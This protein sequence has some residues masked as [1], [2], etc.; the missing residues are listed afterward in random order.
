M[1]A[2]RVG[3]GGYG[4]VTARRRIAGL[5]A[6]LAALS[7]CWPGAHGPARDPVPTADGSSLRASSDVLEG[8]GL[9]GGEAARA[10]AAGG[11]ALIVLGA[12]IASESDRVG[13]FVEIPAD[14]CVLLF[15]RATPAV[16]DL[17]LLAYDDEGNL[18]ASDESPDPQPTALLCPPHPRRV[19]AAARVV[20]G[21]GVVALGAV[22]VKRSVAAAVAAACQARGRGDDTGRLAAWPGL[23]G[24]V[25]AHRASLG[26]R[27]EDAKR[28][29][30]PVDSRV[31]TRVSLAVGA[32]RCLDVLVTPSDEIGSLEVLAEDASARV[33]ARGRERGR[34]RTLLLCSQSAAE[35]SLSLRARASQ[36]LAAVVVARSRVGGEAE[37]SA[38]V[39]IDRVTQSLGLPR[40][41]AA[42]G[43][44][45]AAQDY[46]PP[47]SAGAGTA[48]V[49]RSE[50]VALDLAAGCSRLDVI[51]GQPLG[52]VTADLWDERDARLTS[53]SGG[54][55]A[56]LF[57]CGPG[58][59]VR[60][61][62]EGVAEPGP[63]AVELRRAHLAPAALLA[64]PLAASRLLARLAAAG[65]PGSVVATAS[66]ANVLSLDD[67]SLRTLPFAVV[68]GSCTEVVVALDA[69]GAGVVLRLRE[70]TSSDA[71]IVRAPHVV[72]E[73]VCAPPAGDSAPRSGAAE[74]RLTTGRADALVLVR[75]VPIE[76]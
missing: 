58:G 10:A 41:R 27:W 4:P 65:E 57:S 17:D 48:R 51:A 73:R 60:L 43:R 32:G 70:G 56:T 40:A 8:R 7:G 20:S 14:E 55:G 46:A 68:P 61:D 13:A 26:G 45:L 33:V 66:L 22:S 1:D 72:S 47:R 59:K 6:A 18:F 75:R 76:K 69:G 52:G 44:A 71:S 2:R 39:A 36:G 42:L 53:A 31:A 23:E 15:A 62:I 54:T 35:L 28:L 29:V 49:G 30:V 24:N 16:L 5:G 50:S 64:H 38:A 67:F 12:E 9:L 63:F 34:D 11:G 19:Y 37:L 25:A 21:A 3:D 74:L